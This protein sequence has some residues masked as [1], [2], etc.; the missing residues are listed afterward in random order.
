MRRVSKS[1]N[2]C[3]ISSHN[4]PT[5][6]AEVLFVVLRSR[7]DCFIAVVNLGVP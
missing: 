4:G 7:L 3:L 5:I 1:V 2:Q 6:A